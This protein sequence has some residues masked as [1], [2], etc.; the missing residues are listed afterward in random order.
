VLANELHMLRSGRGVVAWSPLATC[1]LA[2]ALLLALLAVFARAGERVALVAALLSVPV[3]VLA[4]LASLRA[5]VWWS[6]VPYAVAALLAY[7]LWSWRRL[8]HTVALLDRE[9]DHLAAVPP[10]E[11]EAPPDDLAGRLARLHRAGELVHEARSF[12]AG[13]IEGLPA[14]TL[15]GDEAGGVL[16]ANRRAA[17]LF[18]VDDAGELRG[19]DL[20]RL[21][22][23]FAADAPPDWAAALAA[24]RPGESGIA[25]EGRIAG[26]DHVVQAQAVELA[27]RRRVV[28]AIADV[29]PVKQAQR[30]REEALAFVSHDLRSPASS[31]VMLLDLERA[32]RLPLTQAQLLAEVKRL[33]GRVQALADDFVLAARAETRALARAP[34]AVAALLDEVVADLDAPARG[35]GVALVCVEVAPGDFDLDRAL[36]RRAVVNLVGNAIQ[37]APAGSR[38][39]LAAR[40]DGERL[41]LRVRDHGPGLAPDQLAQLAAG[42]TGARAGRARGVG[43]GLLFVQ[44]VA[45]RHGG[46][47]R[48]SA[49][50]GG[51]ACFDLVL[52][53]GSG[54]P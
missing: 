19:L 39:E 16:L 21:L 6:P 9:I 25:A 5:G 8:E 47:L 37:H 1:A 50:D 43:L 12:L 26:G 33:A 24:L 10:D 48:A 53:A 11:A 34:V 20:P 17:A 51:G 35:A 14:A 38:V 40:R 44:R 4:S 31:I 36:V 54:N 22:A 32:G 30:Q 29:A 28:V 2:A 27:G 49:A 7:P 45:R 46:V 3:V 23:E 18:E 15:V 13:A 41:V 42:E 52:G